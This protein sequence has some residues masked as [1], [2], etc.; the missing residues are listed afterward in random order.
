[1]LFPLGYFLESYC[2]LVDKLEGGFARSAQIESSFPMG[3]G[4]EQWTFE[5]GKQQRN[6]LNILTQT[7]YYAHAIMM[8]EKEPIYDLI[9]GFETG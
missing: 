7:M 1:M 8:D 2:L 3:R 4:K 9:F 6:A 5:G